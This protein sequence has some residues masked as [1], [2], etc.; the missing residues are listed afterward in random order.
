[1]NKNLLVEVS[2]KYRAGNPL[3]V[4][5]TPILG[6]IKQKVPWPKPECLTDLLNYSSS[7]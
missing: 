1:M 6:Q 7:S 5:G 3:V 4:P 2:G